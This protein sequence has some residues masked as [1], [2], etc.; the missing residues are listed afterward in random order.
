M[1]PSPFVKWLL[2]PGIWIGATLAAAG[3]LS[4]VVSALIKAG[5]RQADKARG[6]E[7]FARAKRTMT[8]LGALRW[9]LLIIVWITAVVTVL[10][11]LGIEIGPIL[12]GLGV[13]GVAVGLGAQSLVRDMLNGLFIIIENQFRISDV[14]RIGEAVG[15]VEAISLRTTVIRGLDG[16]LY[17]I[18][19][20]EIK[21]V[22]NMTTVWA[23]AIV[24]VGVAYR[25]E[26]ERVVEALKHAAE[27]LKRD[28]AFSAYLMEEAEIKA[29]E[30]FNPSSIEVALWVKCLPSKQ[31]DVARMARRLV[32]RRLE[33]AGIEI[34]FPQ[35]TLSL[36]PKAEE[37]V[38]AR[39]AK[40]PV[41]RRR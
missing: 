28:K 27:D 20:G 30:A 11:K 23:R 13:A 29:I 1:E 3:L 5:I 15:T 8:L 19:N 9:L 32:K 14:V 7:V 12:A 39:F 10:R 40:K 22:E 4:W 34:A 25:S 37:F 33:E 36:H 24:N 16:H 31:W 41:V 2:D 17:T 18:P 21:L 35:V 38:D 6:P 26:I